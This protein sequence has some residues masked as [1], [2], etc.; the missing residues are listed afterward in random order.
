MSPNHHKAVTIAAGFL[1]GTLLW[2]C[3]A[4]DSAP[5]PGQSGDVVAGEEAVEASD[6]LVP[7]VVTDRVLDDTDDP[8]IWIDP[9]DPA[10]SVILGTD[11]NETDGGVYTF[12]LDGRIDVDRTVR[13][14]QRPNNVDVQDGFVFE[15]DTISI[16]V[17]T[18]RHRMALRVFRLPSMD[19][20]DGGGIEVF[21]GPAGDTL[22]APMGVALYRRPSDGQVFAIVGGKTGPVDGYLHQIALADD[23]AGTVTGE[24]VRAF[25][26]FSGQ[27]EIEAIA[28]DDGPGFVYYSDEGVGVRKVHADPAHPEAGNEL[29]L[30]GVDDFAEDH[31]GIAIYPT[32]ATTGYL[33]IS[34]QQSQALNIYRREGTAVDPHA[35]EILLSIPIAALETDGVEA[36]S[37]GLGPDFPL[38]MVVT[39]STDGTFHYYDWRDIQSRL[40]RIGAS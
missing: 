22:R 26:Q 4:P 20:I 8:A 27:K 29:A 25:G 11:K 14:L 15:G 5:A 1:L 7:R 13:G 12:S 32:G 30:F 31:E 17:A 36:T 23:G 19:P 21:G 38:G 10:A 40:D 34:N 3:G 2:A 6:V 37:T 35:H 16:A 33:L 18:E 28:V 9:A 24:L 39:M